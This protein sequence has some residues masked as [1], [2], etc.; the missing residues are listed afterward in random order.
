MEEKMDN[1][2]RIISEE[3]TNENTGEN[4]TGL[5]LMIDGKIKQVF[6]ILVQKSGGTKTYLD[7][8]QEALISGI[9]S[10]IKKLRDVE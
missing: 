9:D 5:T 6:D 2:M 1:K 3:F 7:I 10:Q 8:M 4:V